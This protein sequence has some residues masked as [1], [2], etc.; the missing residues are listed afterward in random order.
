[1]GS[2]QLQVRKAALLGGG[3]LNVFVSLGFGQN[4]YNSLRHIISM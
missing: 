1:M 3:L 4:F 2:P